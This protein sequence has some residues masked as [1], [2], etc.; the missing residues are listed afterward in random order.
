MRILVTGG[1]GFIGSHIVDELVA[2][3]EHEVVVLD[4][5]A[6]E[7]RGVDLVLGDVADPEVVAGAVRGVDAVC[8]QAARV[9]LGLDVMDIADYVRDNALGTAVLLRELARAGFAGRFVLASSM[10]VYGEGG[11]VCAWHGRVA[12]PPR[13]VADLEAGR[14]E[15]VCPVCS[16]DLEAVAVGESAPVDPR[17]VYAATKLQQE[18]LCFAWSRETGV[19]VTGLRYHNVYGPRMP[20]DTPYAG[21]ASIFASALAAGREPRVFE[22]GR[23]RRDFVHVRDAARANL[24]ALTREEPTAGAFNVCSGHP[25]TVGE[26]AWALREAAGP[27]APEPVITGEYRLGDVRHVFASAERAASELGFVAEE[28]FDAGMAEFAGGLSPAAG[29]LNS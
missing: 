19:P 11:Y 15:P 1:A 27:D 5:C 8:H 4:L 29:F 23:Q 6:G 17:N 13:A 3:E 12:P 18:H 16:A 26:M 28:D 22:D 10:V 9:G 21:V 24:L 20:R 25:R 14:F 2:S 7:L